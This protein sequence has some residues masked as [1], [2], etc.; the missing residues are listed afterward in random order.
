LSSVS[1][2]L[3]TDELRQ[4]LK[5]PLGELVKGTIQECNTALRRT[6]ERDKPQLL[7]LVGDTISRNAINAGLTPDIVIIDNKEMRSQA[8]T[9][10]HGKARMFK[11]LNEA[12]TIAQEAW[13]T[14]E[15]SI[16]ARNAVVIVDGEE[17][18]LTLVAIL[19]APDGALVAYG[20]PDNGIVLVRVTAAKKKE[21]ESIVSQMK[22]A[23]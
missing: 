23:P 19:E 15:E 18:L 1:N 7:I 14:V 5:E 16:K 2:H 17:D 6:V 21:I 11:T 12:G 8:I 22:S 3:L 13:K 20:Q 4:R 10:R 9:F